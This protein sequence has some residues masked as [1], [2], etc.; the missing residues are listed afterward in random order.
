MLLSVAQFQGRTV[1]ILRKN[2]Y[3]LL[4]FPFINTFPQINIF[5]YLIYP[6]FITSPSLSAAPLLIS[7]IFSWKIKLKHANVY[8]TYFF[9][10]DAKRH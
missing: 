4:P 5:I 9:F 3:P 8:I 6:N 1:P 10:Q 2:Y 7:C